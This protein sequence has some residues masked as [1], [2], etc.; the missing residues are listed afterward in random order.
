VSSAIITNVR[1]LQGCVS[2]AILFTLNSD[3]C[4]TDIF[5]QYI[6]KYSD[7]TVL[8]SVLNDLFH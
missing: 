7:G 8:I 2:S 1:E 6:L 5:N 3:D 4:R